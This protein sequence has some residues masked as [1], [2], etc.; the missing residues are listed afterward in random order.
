MYLLKKLV[1]LYLQCFPS[2]KV[3]GEPFALWKA[4]RK[5]TEVG[6][7]IKH[8]GGEDQFSRKFKI[9]IHHHQIFD[10]H[11]GTGASSTSV[12][13]LPGNW[14]AACIADLTPDLQVL[15]S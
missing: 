15:L 10:E 9:F 14:L 8:E 1:D 3:K 13:P 11:A 5:V 12:G 6:F 4:Y 2:Q 7:P